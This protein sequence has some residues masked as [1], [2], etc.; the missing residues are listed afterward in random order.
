MHTRVL[1]VWLV[2]LATLAPEALAKGSTGRS[3]FRGGGRRSSR[4]SGFSSRA[5]RSTPRATRT[6][7][8]STS[9]SRSRP[10]SVHRSAPRAT[11]SSS[12]SRSRSTSR[13]NYRRTTPTP[14]RTSRTRSRS[15]TSTGRSLTSTAT[16][17]LTAAPSGLFT[18]TAS[19]STGLSTREFL[20]RRFG[21]GSILERTSRA[22]RTRGTSSPNVQIPNV[23]TNTN[24]IRDRGAGFERPT[25]IASR[26]GNS[27]TG[28]HT[29]ATN[30]N[31]PRLGQSSFHRPYYHG[32]TGKYRGF[33]YRQPVTVVYVPFGF[34][35]GCRTTYVNTSD[36]VRDEYA[37]DEYEAVDPDSYAHDDADALRPEAAAGSAAAERYMRE[38]STLFG[39][40]EYPEAARRFRLA[41]IAAPGEAGPLFA[42]GQALV[43]LKNYPYAAKVT[44]Q[45]LDLEPTLLREG[46]DL[47]AVYGN[48][49]EFDRVQA[50]IQAR[51]KARPD[52]EHALFMLGVGQ[53][54]SGDPG[55]RE[56]FRALDARSRNDRI[57]TG[58]KQAVDERFK[59]AED[60]PEISVPRR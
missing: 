25:G 18:P 11:R 24:V 2:V 54:F 49:E 38:A 15:R 53:Y 44:R 45:A 32:N 6:R 50:T 12:K 57:I 27:F 37:I 46:G 43:A 26:G 16:R 34:Y 55:A 56:T 28:A 8:R 7:S 14:T 51:I 52:D 40:G 48:R 47:V 9:R 39:N 10:N 36:A 60:L 1:L 31:R 42:M 41:A 3:G 4:S 5:R 20:A 21:A 33:H 22:Q 17:R 19:R 58:F 35:G 30:T 13:S 29:R 23:P 59:R